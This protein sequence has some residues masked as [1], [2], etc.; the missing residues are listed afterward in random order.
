MGKT[1]TSF[2]IPSGVTSIG[3]EAF[4]NCYRLTSIK[5]PDS[6][7]S[8]GDFAFR[9]CYRLTSITIPDSVTGI[10]DHAFFSCDSLTDVYYTGSEAEWAN[11]SIRSSNDD[12][13]NARIHY[14]YIPE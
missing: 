11:I 10:G 3:D 9:S 1:V 2:V 8:I 5:I 13:I 12:L 14:N 6:V 7:T 4:Y